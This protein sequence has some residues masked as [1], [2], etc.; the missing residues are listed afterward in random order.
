MLRNGAC[1]LE[2]FTGPV[3]RQI[4]SP[5]PNWTRTLDFTASG[6]LG[7]TNRFAWAPF[8]AWYFGRLA[9][10]LGYQAFEKITSFG[11]A[12]M[13]FFGRRICKAGPVA[14][15]PDVVEFL[16][17]YRIG[18][19]IIPIPF[20]ARSVEELFNDRGHF[21][22]GSLYYAHV[23]TPTRWAGLHA[24]GCLWPPVPVRLRAR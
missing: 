23:R 2:T 13:P 18:A 20:A 6:K 10:Q 22:L 16:I 11:T 1:C 5:R 3:G 9:A 7:K 15:N 24:A 21:E 8:S 17:V 14:E 19:E 12:I 4:I